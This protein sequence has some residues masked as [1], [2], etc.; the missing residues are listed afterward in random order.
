MTMDFHDSSGS[1]LSSLSRLSTA[2]TRSISAENR[3]GEKGRGGMATEGTGAQAARELGRGW[4]VSPSIRI[5]PGETAVLADISG[6]GAIQHLW[7]TT[8]TANWRSLLLRCYWDGDEAPAIEVPVG[9]FFCNGWGRFSQVSSL[10]VAANPHG[11]FNSYWEMP[12][13][14]RARV[15]IESLA[16]ED[17][18][19]Y[20]QLTYEQFEPPEDATFFHAHWRRSNALLYGEEHNLVEVVRN[21]VHVVCTYR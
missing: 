6:A 3:T 15:T 2:R 5:A 20:Y 18:I 19:L 1:G 4:K 11:G 14:Q 12:F 8:H 9:D 16:T 21:S 10:P 7:L 13:R 17:V